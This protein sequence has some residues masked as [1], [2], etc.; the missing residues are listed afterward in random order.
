MSDIWD[1]R[2]KKMEIAWKIARHTSPRLS[3]TNKSQ[4]E[5]QASTLIAVFKSAK[6]ALDEAFSDE[7]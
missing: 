5:L 3:N 1:F 2:M 4:S 7:E 6:E